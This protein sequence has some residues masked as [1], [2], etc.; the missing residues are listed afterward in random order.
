MN[1]IVIQEISLDDVVK[2]DKERF[3]SNN[4]WVN[5]VKP[6]DY[7]ERL[8]ETNTKYWIKN[9]RKEFTVITINDEKHL[10]WMKECAKISSQTGKFSKLFEDEL[11][12]F[13]IEYEGIFNINPNIQY[14]IRTEHVSLKYGQ[15]G[16][17]PYHNLKM[18]TE[19]LV[20]SVSGHTP[21][22]D[23]TT[24]ITLYL[25]PFIGIKDH[26]EFR[27]FVCDKKITAISQQNLY[28]NVFKNI[29]NHKELIEKYINI[30]LK[31]FESDIKNILP[32]NDFTYD[33]AILGED[34]PFFIEPN[35]F[36][37]EYAAGSSLFHWERDYGILYGKG[38]D[39]VYFR[40]T[41]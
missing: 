11:E 4:H 35:S 37:K 32:Y 21:I 31:Y 29:P 38:K 23:D 24:S 41:N 6:E 12:E 22:K 7:E 14:F 5:D 10:R 34:K 17:G 39:D 25:L 28:S 20:S 36:G 27:V 1:N 26:E 8:E 2:Y 9:F 19:S 18:I 30:I 16:I 3:N 13:L 33:F 40:Y 15:H